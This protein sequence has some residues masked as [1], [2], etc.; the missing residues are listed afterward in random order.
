MRATTGDT[1]ERAA[2]IRNAFIVEDWKPYSRNSLKGFCRVVLSSGLV[3]AEVAIHAS[4]DCAWAPAS[5]PMLS[6]EGAVLRDEAGKIRYAPI[7]A[8]TSKARRDVFSR[9]VIEALL[10]SYPE[11]L[12]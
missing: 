1:R 7:V 4:G 9:L 11:A 2:A 8:F 6:P 10:A 5:K 12:G 3:L